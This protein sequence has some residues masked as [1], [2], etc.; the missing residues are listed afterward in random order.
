M[1][2]NI[3]SVEQVKS[4]VQKIVGKKIT[5]VWFGYSTFIFLELGE[6]HLE[7]RV[8]RKGEG[9]GASLV[10]DWTLG[11]APYWRVLDKGEVICD[12]LY[13]EYDDLLRIAYGFEKKKIV[14]AVLADSLETLDVLLS[15][16]VTVQFYR[17]K[18]DF[19][20]LSYNHKTF[21]VVGGNY[22]PYYLHNEL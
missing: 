8:K 2:K 12:S 7:Y 20:C 1:V 16:G 13:A 15:S 10:G 19:F 21:L 4:N 11:Q 9:S 14:S 22:K 6:L 18:N 3:L 17:G 5:R